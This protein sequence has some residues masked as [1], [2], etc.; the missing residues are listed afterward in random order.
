MRMKGARS[1]AG[2]HKPVGDMGYLC[3]DNPLH[4]TLSQTH[5]S[6]NILTIQ[7]V[8]SNVIDKVSSRNMQVKP[9]CR[10]SI[11]CV[12]AIVIE[13]VEGPKS[14]KS[15][16]GVHVGTAKVEAPDRLN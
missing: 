3:S 8:R 13:S 2:K 9:S 15:T 4:S 1:S 5:S 7:I 16:L 14:A 10:E 12:G 6:Q 11:L